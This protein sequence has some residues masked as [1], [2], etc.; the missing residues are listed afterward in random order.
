MNWINVTLPEMNRTSSVREQ[1]RVA[2]LTALLLSILAG[3]G[4]PSLINVAGSVSVD[5]KAAE[6]AVILFHPESGGLTVSTA[7][8]NPDGT[9]SVVTDM[10]PG[11]PP[12]VYKLSVT[13][14][15]PSIKP[16]ENVPFGFGET[17][18]RPDL[19]KGKYTR[20]DQSG[21]SVTVDSTTKQLQPIELSTR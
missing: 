14:P 18:D 21:L 2:M 13:W 19:L 17:A 16:R 15:D 10:K 7:E 3:C 4:G 20:K 9:F 5:G 12:G 11:I 6:G 1:G 8:S